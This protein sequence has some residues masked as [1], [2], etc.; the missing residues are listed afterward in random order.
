[1]ASSDFL[2]SIWFET[3]YANA[4]VLIIIR[5]CAPNNIGS[6]ES[7]LHS[8]STGHLDSYYDNRHRIKCI[9][10]SETLRRVFIHEVPSVQLFGIP[11][12]NKDC[13]SQIRD[14]TAS[15]FFL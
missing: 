5:A 4:L 11:S 3:I 6:T 15:V 9:V 12:K 10:H 14:R 13:F 1:M 7:V 2:I 8:T